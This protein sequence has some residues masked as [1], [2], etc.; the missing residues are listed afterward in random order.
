MLRVGSIGLDLQDDS[1]ELSQDN[2]IINFHFFG[3]CD[4]CHEERE[5]TS[6]MFCD[7]CQRKYHYFDGWQYKC[8]CGN[9]VSIYEGAFDSYY[10]E[11]GEAGL[12]ADEFY[13]EEY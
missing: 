2:K 4:K 1:K 7:H 5:L 8:N 3:E 11:Y 12:I 13:E 6:S 10:D 9:T